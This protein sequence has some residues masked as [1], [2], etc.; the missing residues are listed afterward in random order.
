MEVKKVKKIFI[1][2]CMLIVCSLLYA[3]KSNENSDDV[4]ITYG[5][6]EQF[7]DSEMEDAVDVIIEKFKDFEGCELIKIWYDESKANLEVERYIARENSMKK[8][9]IIIFYSDFKVD[10]TGKNP[11][12][13]PDST[14]T[15]W[16]WIL[17]RDDITK[18]WTVKDWGY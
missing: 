7:S 1:V 16:M 13:N 12:L 11:V 8:E 14:Y 17:T 10:S 18:E 5:E 3:C 9:N 6:S 4:E 15:D 2:L